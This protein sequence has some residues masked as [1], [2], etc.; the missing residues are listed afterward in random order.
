MSGCG[1][2]RAW[3]VSR[4]TGTRVDLISME[5]SGAD[6]SELMLT[7]YGPEERRTRKLAEANGH[8]RWL[9]WLDAS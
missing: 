1:C 5:A 8:G 4:A 3:R 9:E 6:F 7:T 2:S